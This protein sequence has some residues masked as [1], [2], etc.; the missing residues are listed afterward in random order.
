MIK[1]FEPDI[2]IL[3]LSQPEIN[4]PMIARLL[5][6]NWPHL[7]IIVASA[8]DG[9]EAHLPTRTESL[10]KPYSIAAVVE[11]IVRL[12]YSPSSDL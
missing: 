12:A 9:Y 1:S 3:D 10:P 8:Q 4:G 7:P 6:E 11:A 5:R 2:L